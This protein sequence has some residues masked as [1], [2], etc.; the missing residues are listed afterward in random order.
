VRLWVD[1]LRLPPDA[2]W[3]WARTSAEAI[4]C[5][6][7]TDYDEMS[8]DH[9]LGGDDTSRSVVLWLCENASRWPKKIRV[10][11]MNNVGR[12]WLLGMIYRYS[13]YT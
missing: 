6:Q 10:H 12:E 4:A 13:P 5:L 11:S 8:L 3:A 2:D 1:D 9:D 7:L